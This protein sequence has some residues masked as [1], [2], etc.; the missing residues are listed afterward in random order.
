MLLD[1]FT[2]IVIPGY[3][4]L[5]V[6]NFNLFTLNFSVIGNLLGRKRAFV[7][8]GIMTGLYFY[9]VLKEVSGGLNLPKRAGRLTDAAL[10]FLFF[11]VATPYLPDELPFKSFLHIVFA[12]CSSL[13]LILYLHAASVRLYRFDPQAGQLA[14]LCLGGILAVSAALLLSVGII[15]SALEIF[16]T[17]STVFLSRF[18]LSKARYY[19]GRARVGLP[20]GSVLA[21]CAQVSVCRVLDRISHDADR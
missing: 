18:L 5:F 7:V 6:R 17:F 20:E 11:A 12:L 21:A 14:L 9:R 2:F 1:F 4:L 16:F 10:L 13:C 19:A 8:W 15:S 3:T